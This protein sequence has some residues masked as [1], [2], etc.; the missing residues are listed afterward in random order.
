MTK[1]LGVGKEVL[2]YCSKC[3]LTLSHLIVAMKSP[4]TINKVVCKTCKATH[5]YKDPNKASKK[6]VIPHRKKAEMRNNE[7]TWEEALK[8]SSI[9][10]VE[11]SPKTK[12]IKGDLINHPTFGKGVIEKLVDKNKIEVLFKENRKTLVHN[13]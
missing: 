8:Q 12:F 6:K 9:K 5:S 11:Y 1:E 4:K 10:M 13:I 3:K 7:K 2:S